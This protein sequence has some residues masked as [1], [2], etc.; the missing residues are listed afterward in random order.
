MSSFDMKSMNHFGKSRTSY[1][2]YVFMSGRGGRGYARA[3]ALLLSSFDLTWLPTP[4]QISF[5]LQWPPLL[6]FKR[7]RKPTHR[8]KISSGSYQS[9]FFQQLSEIPYIWLAAPNMWSSESPRDNDHM[10]A[11]FGFV[12]DCGWAIQISCFRYWIFFKI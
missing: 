9:F 2:E 11:V 7:I 4:R 3:L 8:N 5:L 1:Y 12:M 6:Q 10:L